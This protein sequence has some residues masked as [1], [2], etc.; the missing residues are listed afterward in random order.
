MKLDLTLI[1]RIHNSI[2]TGATDCPN[3]LARKFNISERSFHIYI[4]E[5][6]RRW[7]AP[8]SYCHTR[9]TYYYTRKFELYFGDLS[10]V[11]AKLEKEIVEL[12][13]KT[14]KIAILFEFFWL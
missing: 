11:K 5:M 12:I 1:E 13:A 3:C 2:S 14:L 6:K 10:P 4:S 9:K 8:I 7:N